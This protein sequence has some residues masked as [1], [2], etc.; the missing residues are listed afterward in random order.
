MLLNNS[1]KKM[2]HSS[3]R[4]WC[5][6]YF[7]SLSTWVKYK[8]YVLININNEKN[9]QVLLRLLHYKA[10]IPKKMGFPFFPLLVSPSSTACLTPSTF[11]LGIVSNAWETW[12][13]WGCRKTT[14]LDDPL[15]HPAE[16]IPIIWRRLL[17]EGKR[18]K[19]KGHFCNSTVKRPH[20]TC[21]RY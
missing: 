1:G 13:G 14:L 6:Y 16:S 18:V 12:K 11:P 3:E 21:S 7:I 10:L 8:F 20:L 5:S 17:K 4:T 9:P 19:V 15:P 2:L